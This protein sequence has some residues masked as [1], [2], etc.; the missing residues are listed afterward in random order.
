MYTWEVTLHDNTIYAI[1]IDDSITVADVLK[2]RGYILRQTS[3][4]NEDLKKWIEQNS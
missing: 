2:I 4:L 3:S 1:D